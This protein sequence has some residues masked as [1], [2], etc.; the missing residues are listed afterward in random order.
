MDLPERVMT[1]VVRCRLGETFPLLFRMSGMNSMSCRLDTDP[2]TTP[3][4][5][6]IKEP[7][8]QCAKMGMGEVVCDVAGQDAVRS[9]SMKVNRINEDALDICRLVSSPHFASRTA[10]GDGGILVDAQ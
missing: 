9:A 8:L 2:Y 7:R 3:Q 10:N 5:E 4:L 6:K 1:G